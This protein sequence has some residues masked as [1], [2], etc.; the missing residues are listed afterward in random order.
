MSPGRRPAGSPNWRDFRGEGASKGDLWYQQCARTTGSK[1][2][3]NAGTWNQVGNVQH[4]TYVV[5]CLAGGT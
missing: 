1:G 4:M 3:G 2:T 5:R